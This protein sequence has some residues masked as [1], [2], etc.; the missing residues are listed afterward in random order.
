MLL[1]QTEPELSLGDDAV[2]L[3]EGYVSTQWYDERVPSLDPASAAAAARDLPA[4]PWTS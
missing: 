2:L 3:L 4:E 1:A